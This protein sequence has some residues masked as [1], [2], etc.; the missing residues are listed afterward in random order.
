MV[1]VDVWL[2]QQQQ[3][4]FLSRWMGWIYGVSQVRGRYGKVSETGTGP[5]RTRGSRITNGDDDGSV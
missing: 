2:L 5:R 3:L 1:V 4:A